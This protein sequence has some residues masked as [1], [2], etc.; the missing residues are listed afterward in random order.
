MTGWRD[1]IF[2]EGARAW[3]GSHVHVTGDVEQVHEQWW[4][5]VL[6]A[7]TP[8]GPVWF[9]AVADED[10]FEPPLTA[11]L[12]HSRPDLVAEPIA[13]DRDRGWM[14]MRDGGIRLS[15]L[16]EDLGVWE[17]ILPAYAEL[18]LATAALV[19]ELLGI[20]VSD[21]RLDALPGRLADLLGDD[22]FLM[23]DEPDG[24]S[25]GDRDRLEGGLPEV[26]ALCREVAAFGIPDTIQHDDL[27]GGNV[28]VRDGRHRVV[29]WGDACVSHP[30]HS[31]TVLLRAT[32]WRLDLE[33]GG[34]ELLRMRDAY[35]EP[36]A[37]FGT[38]DE[39]T[40]AAG[41]AYRTGTLARSLA[42]ARF[43]AARLPDAP[44]E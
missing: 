43:L 17:A 13:I 8:D 26:E 10:R 21:E 41:M 12:A 37:R 15:D 25:S 31:L 7:P 23:L 36:F 20:G 9:K 33:P 4:S 3:I 24:L 35:L 39:L 18:Q 40:E 34:S 44:R 29:D 5:T 27:H 11:M 14:L 42:W 16:G 30:F 19:R 28:L 22:A 2:L 1:P 32:A 6:R 38:R